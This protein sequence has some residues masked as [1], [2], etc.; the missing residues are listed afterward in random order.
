M[1]HKL[2]F[3]LMPAVA[4]FAA[5][6]P[7]ILGSACTGS[8]GGPGGAA[9]TS[10]GAP[11]PVVAQPTIDPAQAL[12]VSGVRLMGDVTS[13][14]AS[15]DW[16]INRDGFNIEGN[17]EYTVQSPGNLHLVVH[18]RGH[19]DVPGKFQE[20]NDSELLILGDRSYINSPP[21]GKG[22]VLFTQQE[23]GG[24]WPMIQ[25]LVAA[26]SPIDFKALASGTAGGAT[27]LG[28][29]SIDGH[30][31]AHYQA[32]V[33]AGVVMN[34]LADAYGSQ[35]HIMLAD[36]FS[37]QITIDVWI[38]PVTLLPRRLKAGGTIPYLGASTQVS[39]TV[40]L[41]EL[42]RVS[43]LPAAPHDATPLQQLGR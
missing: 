36:R 39:V 5:V 25:R 24:D 16:T 32:P 15:L 40:D 38:D 17:G 14:R 4:V 34:A 41:T 26:H 11:S 21:L 19:G 3:G 33:D 8:G 27:A 2:Q 10:V 28:T 1:I 29:D 6:L 42:N 20:A 22:W 7:G 43:S 9:A 23:L 31:Y 30:K 18:Y 12:E 35:G 37:G 13:G